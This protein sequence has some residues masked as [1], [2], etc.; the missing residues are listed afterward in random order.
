MTPSQTCQ[1]H[2]R[3]FTNNT[4]HK[5]FSFSYLAA[6]TGT[7]SLKPSLSI[8]VDHPPVT[9]A[10]T[11][12]AGGN[13][14]TRQIQPFIPFTAVKSVTVRRIFSFI[15]KRLKILL[16]YYHHDEL[17]S[18]ITITIIIIVSH[19]EKNYSFKILENVSFSMYRW[20][21]FDQHP[22][23]HL[24]WEV[25]FALVGYSLSLFSCLSLRS[26]VDLRSRESDYPSAAA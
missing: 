10:R 6:T 19:L 18:I 3:I 23:L 11:G 17:W 7:T 2:S 16:Q 9:T 20:T 26:Y 12:S 8:L 25:T 22:L 24:K 14:Y 21:S 5:N 15:N 13:G 1:P 4:T